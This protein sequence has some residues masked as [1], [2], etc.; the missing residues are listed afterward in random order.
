MAYQMF[1]LFTLLVT[2]FIKT[3]ASFLVL[4]FL[5][6][7]KKLISAIKTFFPL[8]FIW[9]GIPLMNPKS[10]FFLPPLTPNNQSFLYPGG[11][12]AHYKNLTE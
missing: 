9:T 3:G 7:H 2:S 11:V 1:S 4:R 8:T 5:C 12:R 6:T 10:L